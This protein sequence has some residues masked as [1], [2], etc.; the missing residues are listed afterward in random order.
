MTTQAADPADTFSAVGPIGPDTVGCRKTYRQ[1][2]NGSSA[3][4]WWPVLATAPEGW[5]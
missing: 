5:A 1:E 2:R 4:S 3:A